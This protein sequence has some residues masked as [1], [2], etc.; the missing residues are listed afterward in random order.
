MQKKVFA[1]FQSRFILNL[2]SLLQNSMY[3]LKEM[4]NLDNMAVNHNLSILRILQK[5]HKNSVIT[6]EV[7]TEFALS[8]YK[9]T[10]AEFCKGLKKHFEEDLL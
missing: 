9:Q 5:T 7:G 4:G 1:K 10:F 2:M 3:R 8:H 6:S